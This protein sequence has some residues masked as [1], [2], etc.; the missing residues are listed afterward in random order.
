MKLYRSRYVKRIYLLC[1]LAGS[2]TTACAQDTTEVQ[3]LYN[4]A[5]QLI[6]KDPAKSREL[7]SQAVAMGRKIGWYKGTAT[8]HSYVGAASRFLGDHAA[9]KENLREAYRYYTKANYPAGQAFALSQLASV[10]ATEGDY[11]KALDLQLKALSISESIADTANQAITHTN[12]AGIYQVLRRRAKAVE[13]HK[14]ALRL[15][16]AWGNQRSISITHANMAS[17]FLDMEQYDEAESHIRKALLI[18]E[19]LNDAQVIATCKT[20]LGVI[21]TVRGNPAQGLKLQEEAMS[22]YEVLGDSEK[23]ARCWSSIADAH[24]A[25]GN[26]EQ[27]IQAYK[28]GEELAA[29]YPDK[30]ILQHIYAG[31]AMAHADKND[32]ENAYRFKTLSYNLDTAIRSADVNERISLLQEEFEASKKDK[33]IAQLQLENERRRLEADRR[34]LL[35]LSGACLLLGIVIAGIFYLRQRQIAEQKT[36]TE[37]EQKAL[38]AQMNPHFLFNSLN[39][40]Q[41]MYTGGEQDLANEYIEDFSLLLRRILDNSGKERIPVKEELETLRLYLQLEKARNGKLLDYEISVDEHIDQLN[42]WI[43]SMVIQPLVENAIWHGILPSKKP[44]KVRIHL[45]S[46]SPGGPIVCTV[47]DNGIGIEGRTVGK[48]QAHDPKGLELTRQRLGTDLKIEQ[49][50][51]GTRVTMTI[52]V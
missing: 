23:M 18:Q 6:Y 27:T 4:E 37:L 43:P 36:K 41:D 13:H 29:S 47:E 3:A 24:R 46:A 15:K 33:A 20:N 5:A 40:I 52:S 34:N 16:K 44:G 8:A 51:P 11:G 25:M 42:T 21:E 12:I 49:L 14:R 32:Y 38:R 26:I 35:L 9:A 48:Q 39:A 19:E 28:K 7:A 50:E 45:A 17:L 30:L 31:L 22:L 10:K 1:F 2:Y